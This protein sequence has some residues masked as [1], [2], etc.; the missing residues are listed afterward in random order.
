MSSAPR[1][2]A[3]VT[4]IVLCGGRSRRF[5]EDKTQAALHGRPVLD[6]LL[7]SLPGGWDVI[8]VGHERPTTRAGVRWTREDPAGGGPVAALAAGLALVSAPTVVLLG[9]DMPFG[10]AAAARL[11][12]DLVEG[13][14]DCLVASSVGA[15]A[16]SAGPRASSRPR[17]SSASSAS[18]GSSTSSASSASGGPSGPD[19]M[20]DPGPANATAQPLLSAM[21]TTALRAAVPAAPA[22][23]PLRRLFDTLEHRLVLLPDD[24]SLDID[25]HEDL[26]R[27]ET[28]ARRLAP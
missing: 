12:E 10:G 27:A 26:A 7:D 14:V 1:Q 2:H 4:A 28:V 11:A 23:L 15:R 18:G 20:G 25:T 21:R 24:A 13:S 6:W 5:G 16:S 19:R 8:C 9:G 17:A 22:G 3:D